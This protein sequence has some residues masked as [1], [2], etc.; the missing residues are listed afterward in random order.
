[1]RIL[2][3]WA[4]FFFYAVESSSSLPRFLERAPRGA[5]RRHSTPRADGGSTRGGACRTSGTVRPPRRGAVNPPQS[6]RKSLARVVTTSQHATRPAA[7]DAPVS[8][9][10]PL[11]AGTVVTKRSPWRLSI[12]TDIFWS[13][14]NL[15]AA[16]CV[17]HPS[18]ANLQTR[19]HRHQIPRL[20]A[21]CAHPP[22]SSSHAPSPTSPARS[23]QTMIDPEYAERYGGKK[24]APRR[25]MGGFGGGG[26]GGGGGMGGG[27]AARR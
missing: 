13:V 17:P 23:F 8:T 18:P 6:R 2:F 10:S 16:L 26:S 22:V 1:M 3:W 5:G 24:D 11:D 7:S 12:I 9:P 21:R 4:G 14:V 20:A 25:P 19:A 27:E 15:I